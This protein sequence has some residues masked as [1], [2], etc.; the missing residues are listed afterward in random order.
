MGC[1]PSKS[2]PE[3][4]KIDKVED[5]KLYKGAFVQHNSQPFQEVYQVGRNIGTGAFGEVRRVIHR[6]T[7]ATRA[8][9]IFRKDLAKTEEATRKLNLE[10][11]ILKVLDHPIIIKVY[12]FFEDPKRFYIIMEHCKGGELFEEIVKRQ[13]F[14]EVHAAQIIQ[15]LLSAVGYLHDTGIVHRD[16]KP[17]NI[18]LEER[19]DDLNI[20][21]IDFG[22]A[23][24]LEKN[25]TIRGALG[26]AYYIAPEVLTGYYNERCDM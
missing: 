16:L 14:G 21:L 24:F 5:I 1:Y 19:N 25:K 20:K 18:L 2:K 6:Q 9:K 17:E 7:G 3:G 8:A 11:D 26:T 22:T 12:E 15:Q 10:I 23:C 4:S 13:S